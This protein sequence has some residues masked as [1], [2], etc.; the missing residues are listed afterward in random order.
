LQYGQLGAGEGAAVVEANPATRQADA[1]KYR[2][3]RGL[4]TQAADA[5]AFRRLRGIR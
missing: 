3:Q 1:E 2:D 4:D 5:A